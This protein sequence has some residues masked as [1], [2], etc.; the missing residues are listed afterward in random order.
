M[1]KAAKPGPADR[2]VDALMA[3]AAET[4]WDGIEIGDIA[5]RAGLTLAEMRDV[6]PSK[7]ALLGLF[8]KRID[9]EVL[10][11]ATDVQASEMAKDRIFDVLM[12]RIDA[13]APYKTALKAIRSGMRRD[14]LALPALN[15]VALNSMR[16]MLAAAGVETEDALGHLKV[17]GAVL[18][19][20]RVL[21]TWF[22]DE[23]PDL[24]RTMAA[25]DR[26][27]MRGGQLLGV[28]GEIHRLTAPLRAFCRA[29][30][31][32]GARIRERGRSPR[33]GRPADE[34][35]VSV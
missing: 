25:L 35:I 18:A 1:V 3:L 29:L 26:E 4:G 27:L 8:A 16:Y 10:E 30:Q 6:A 5:T 17:Q 24:G 22:D 23:S 9:R 19:F 20:A 21:D 15:G 32:T 14:P 7:G 12:R 28:A 33:G 11:A 34:D 13:L 31:D 2:A